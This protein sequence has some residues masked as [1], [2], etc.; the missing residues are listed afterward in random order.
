MKKIIVSIFVIVMIGVIAIDL[1]RYNLVTTN[2]QNSMLFS[3]G[4][5]ITKKIVN[6]NIIDL[7]TDVK[8]TQNGVKVYLTSSR[9]K[10]SKDIVQQQT[11]NV[12]RLRKYILD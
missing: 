11:A 9:V 5:Q 7:T 2:R 12:G 4:N 8:L 6:S 1:Y 10:K 3:K